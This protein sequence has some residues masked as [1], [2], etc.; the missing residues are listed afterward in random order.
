MTTDSDPSDVTGDQDFDFARRLRQIPNQPGVYLFKD[1]QDRVIYIGKAARLQS[2]LRQ[3]Q[4][5]HDERFFVDLLD[6]VLGA[7]EVV[8]TPTEKDALLLESQ[9]IK[10]HQPRFNVQLKDDKRF[11]HLRIGFEHSHPRLEV[12]QTGYR[13]R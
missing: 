5:R 13:Q 9:L 1:R 3:Y 10:L 7:I 6:H 4:A 2:R 11:I 8:R 12:A